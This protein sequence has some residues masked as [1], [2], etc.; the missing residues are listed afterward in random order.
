[1][2]TLQIALA[3][4]STCTVL[5]STYTICILK[6]CSFV[7]RQMKELGLCNYSRVAVFVLNQ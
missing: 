3:L 1:M 7:N 2:H 4:L 5:Y 6:C